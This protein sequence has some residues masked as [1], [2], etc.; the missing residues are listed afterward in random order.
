MRR[1]ATEGDPGLRGHA[2]QP[3]TA[4]GQAPMFF[5][6]FLKKLNVG[7]VTLGVVRPVREE[8]C[9]GDNIQKRGVCGVENFFDVSQSVQGL[10]LCGPLPAQ[11]LGAT[12]K[13]GGTASVG[14]QLVAPGRASVGG[15]M[16]APGRVYVCAQVGGCVTASVLQAAGGGFRIMLKP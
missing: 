15:G 6:V 16:C 4:T 7:P 9:N 1:N 11:F 13:H 12:D 14:T 8:H 10:L 2:P 3:T 5:H